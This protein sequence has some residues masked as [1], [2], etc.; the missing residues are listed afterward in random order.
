MLNTGVAYVNLETTLEMR[1][2]FTDG[3]LQVF[4]NGVYY[5]QTTSNLPAASD[6]LF[7]AAGGG[8]SIAIADAGMHYTRIESWERMPFA[9]DGFMPVP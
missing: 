9:T 5:A 2:N 4:I 7:I 6:V 8:N 1:M 3:V